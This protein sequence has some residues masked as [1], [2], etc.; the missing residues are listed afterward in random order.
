MPPL[1]LPSPNEPVATPP[2]D[3]DSPMVTFS[4]PSRMSA[5]TAV[6]PNWRAADLD[7]RR[8]QPQIDV[9]VA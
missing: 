2:K 5:A 4:L 1:A 9:E 3:C 8:G 6:R 7:A